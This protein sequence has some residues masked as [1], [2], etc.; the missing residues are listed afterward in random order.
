MKTERQTFFHQHGKREL[1]WCTEDC[2]PDDEE[3]DC[4]GTGWYWQTCLLDSCPSG[5]FATEAL[6]LADAELETMLAASGQWPAT[7]RVR[8]FR[9]VL[10][11]LKNW[12]D[13]NAASVR[14]VFA[15]L[16]RLYA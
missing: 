13:A 2:I 6:A 16:Q 14:N 15:S 1:C 8:A 11:N 4:R 7:D 5:P 10:R 12:N 3:G 9:A